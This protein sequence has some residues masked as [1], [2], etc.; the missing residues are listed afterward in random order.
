MSLVTKLKKAKNS[1]TFIIFLA[2][3]V[4]W[5]V[6]ISVTGGNFINSRNISNLLRQMSITGILSI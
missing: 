4:I 5:A 6:F 2:L 1:N 3:L